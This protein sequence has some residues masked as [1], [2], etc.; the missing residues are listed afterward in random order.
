MR[1]CR[2]RGAA[3][4]RLASA[5]LDEIFEEAAYARFLLRCGRDAGRE[6][7][8]A[9]LQEREVATARKPRCC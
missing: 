5:E 3:V 1:R 7:Y 9:F 2:E 6:S 4:I 8:A